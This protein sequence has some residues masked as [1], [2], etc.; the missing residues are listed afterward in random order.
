MPLQ[1][2]AV[3]ILDSTYNIIHVSHMFATMFEYTSIELIGK[4]ICLLLI[5]VDIKRSIGPIIE[6]TARKKNG[7]IFQIEFSVIEL[8]TRYFNVIIRDIYQCTKRIQSDFLARVSHELRTPMNGILGMTSILKAMDLTIEQHLILDTIME[9][10]NMML[11]LVNDILD[12]S[13]LSVKKFILEHLNF[14][15]GA[16]VNNVASMLIHLARAKGLH[17]HIL[18]PPHDLIVI[19]DI[20]RVQQ[21]LMNIIGN[22]IKF[23]CTGEIVVNMTYTSFKTD[24][25]KIRISVRDTGIGIIPSYVP[26]LFTEFS[27]ADI[28]TTRRFDGTGLGL[29][30][31]KE[32]VTLMGGEIGMFPNEDGCGSTFWFTLILK[33]KS[34]VLIQSQSP[35]RILACSDSKYVRE[36]LRSYLPAQSV[37]ISELEHIDLQQFDM[38]IYDK[39]DLVPGKKIIYLKYPSDPIIGIDRLYLNKPVIRSELYG[40]IDDIII[41]PSKKHR[42]TNS[43]LQSGIILLVEDNIINQKVIRMHLKQFGYNVDI[44]NNGR[45]AL[46]QLRKC[47]TYKLILMDCHMP[48]MDGFECTRLIRQESVVYIIAVTGDITNRDRC[49]ECGMNEVMT[50][51]VQTSDIQSVLRRLSL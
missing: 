49:I 33:L 35:K 37:I 26:L 7:S 16:V 25:I 51:P 29:S 45:D 39:I 50:K 22:A 10:G 2:D 40:Y 1:R 5:D 8:E 42:S 14:D 13:K 48:T 44:A 6:H 19:G 46:E 17:L 9:S 3:A 4:H 18:L 32:I 34:D 11:H 27:Q 20:I 36:M 23:T 28:S 24:S 47:S 21:I 38:I 30:I 12:F 31:A 41:R 15:I 43:I